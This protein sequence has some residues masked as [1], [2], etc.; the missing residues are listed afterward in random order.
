MFFH[1]FLGQPEDWLPVMRG[2]SAAGHRCIALTLPGHG[3]TTTTTTT[4]NSDQE[5]SSYSLESTAP[6]IETAL[7][8]HLLGAQEECAVVGYSLGARIALLLAARQLQLSGLAIKK[9]VA[10]SGT[11]GIENDEQRSARAVV[12][13]ERAKEL[14]RRGVDAFINEWYLAAMWTPLRDRSGTFSRLV[15]RKK[16][17]FAGM[18]GPLSAALEWMSPGRAPSVWK[19][20]EYMAVVDSQKEGGKSDVSEVLLVTGLDDVKFT[21]IAVEAEKRSANF[22]ARKSFP[23]VGHAVHIEQPLGLLRE[24]QRYLID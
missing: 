20:I 22:V 7:S 23:G 2:L 10:V 14:Q 15:E 5:S 3:T 13:S 6:A 17:V 18:E 16:R 1:G 21:D 24:L 9:V 11:P 12:D 8:F 19:E 4:T